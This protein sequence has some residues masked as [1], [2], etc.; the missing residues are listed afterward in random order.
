MCVRARAVAGPA[1]SRAV[2]VGVL[3]SANLAEPQLRAQLLV[4]ANQAE[5]ARPVLRVAAGG[6]NNAVCLLC[7][8]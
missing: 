8:Y 7:H 1:N 5:L 3:A 6:L 4:Q 2:A